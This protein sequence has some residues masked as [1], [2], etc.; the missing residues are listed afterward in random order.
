MSSIRRA[1]ENWRGERL[2][3]TGGG[4]RPASRHSIHCSHAARTTQR[5]RRTF[6]PET[7]TQD[8][9]QVQRQGKTLQQIFGLAPGQG[10]V[11][12]TSI[13]GS[14]LPVRGEYTVSLTV[15]D[16][17]VEFKIGGR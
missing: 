13:F 16:E 9:A 10:T 12:S 4:S 8:P 6:K 15:G 5:L 1:S 11:V 2:T 3:A 14:A 17:P 7:T